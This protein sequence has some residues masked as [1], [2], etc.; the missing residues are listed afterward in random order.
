MMPRNP[1]LPF[2][3]GFPDAEGVAYSYSKSDEDVSQQ[4]PH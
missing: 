1:P 3:P 2:R 4:A